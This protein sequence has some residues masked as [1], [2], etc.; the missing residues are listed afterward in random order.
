MMRLFCAWL[1][2]AGIASTL[3]SAGKRRWHVETFPFFQ[4]GEFK[5][6]EV[7]VTLQA[8]LLSGELGDCTAVLQQAVLRYLGSLPFCWWV[9]V[10]PVQCGPEAYDKG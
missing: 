1:L 2:E 9:R 8:H 4:Y 10:V 3:S 5:L 6:R 7:D